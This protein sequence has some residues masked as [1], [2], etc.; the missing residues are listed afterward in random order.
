[1]NTEFDD[2]TQQYVTKHN[3]SNDGINNTPSHDFADILINNIK[4]DQS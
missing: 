4:W 3:L 2:H 1:M